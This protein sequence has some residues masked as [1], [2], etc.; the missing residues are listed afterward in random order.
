[1]EN[2]NWVAILVAVLG[3]AG[4]GGAIT[5]IA[6][7]VKMARNGVSFR[8]DRRK[9]DVVAQRDWALEQKAQAESE[10]DTAEDE[11]DEE[12]KKRRIFEEEHARLR[13]IALEAGV[14]PGPWPNT[15][16]PEVD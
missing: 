9:A 2:F 7:L 14:D 13:L 5:S 15:N 10:R 16:T 8:E 11:R 1:M 4:I 6:G 12:R 3:S